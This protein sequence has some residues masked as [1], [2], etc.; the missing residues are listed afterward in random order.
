[1][2]N[3]V[4]VLAAAAAALIPTTFAAAGAPGDPRILEALSVSAYTVQDL[5]LPAQAG[6]AFTVAVRLGDDLRAVTFEPHS[7]RAAGFAVRIQDAAGEL[8]EIPVP[9]ETTYRGSVADAPGA[10]VAGGLTGEGLT[11]SIRMPDGSSWFITPLSSVIAG[12]PR[13]RCLVYREADGVPTGFACGVGDLDAPPHALRELLRPAGTPGGTDGN[14]VCELACDADF[15]FYTL[16]GS[17]TT[18]V[19][20][21]ITNIVNLV[22]NIYENDCQVEFTITQIIIRTSAASNPY[23]SSTPATLLNQFRSYWLAN[24]GNVPRDLAHLFTGRNLDGSVIGIAYLNGVC[25]TNAFG[26]AQSRFTTNVAYRVGLSA[27][28]M[29]HNFSAPHCD[30]VCSPCKI[31]CSGLG[32]CSGIVSQFS[33]CDIASITSY[34]AVLPCLTPPPPPVLTLPFFETFPLETLDTTKWAS[35]TG[36]VISTL[37]QNERSAPNSLQLYMD[38]AVTTRDINTDAVPPVFVSFWTQ[39]TG[40][41]AGKQLVASYWNVA[42]QQFQPLLAVVSDGVDQTRFAFNEVTLP[43]LG[44]SQTAGK[45][46]FQTFSTEL[47]DWWFVDD[48]RV[49][50]YCRADI[51]QD[52]ALT[53]AD[54]G[55]FQT[56]FASGNMEIADFNDDGV[57]TIADF[58]AYQSRFVQGCY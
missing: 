38:G 32:G 8:H 1:M 39:H 43:F 24:H 34:A 4:R 47:N 21:D 48:I 6:A 29:G 51:N 13:G 22:S 54:F 9:P 3:L 37:A 27:H 18:S 11:A 42:A 33:S 5:A 45:F 14:S 35:N 26:L 56:A 46:R 12:E 31:M 44:Y 16:L 57:L 15:E 30:T 41:E 40:V 2:R 17:N 20:N 36:G 19:T 52:R 25:N 7:V 55:A 10:L 50:L 53:I 58:A 23:T 49:S 28:E